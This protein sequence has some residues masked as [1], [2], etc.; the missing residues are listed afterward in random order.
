MQTNDLLTLIGGVML[1]IIGWFLRET[2]TDLKKV[3]EQAYKTSTKVEVL[4]AE[5]MVK[6]DN[7]NQKF[8]LL[9]AGIK[10][11]TREIAKLNERIKA[12]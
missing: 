8:D 11:L 5:Y 10:D 3:K 7:L 2:M 1:A 6:I 9:Y 4:E 12:N